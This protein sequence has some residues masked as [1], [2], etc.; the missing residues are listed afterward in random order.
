M[1]YESPHAYKESQDVYMYKKTWIEVTSIYNVEDRK[2]YKIFG[3]SFCT[4]VAKWNLKYMDCQKKIKHNC[5]LFYEI[6]N[7]LVMLISEYRNCLI[8]P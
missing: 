2:L 4:F 8:S 5:L 6:L 3:W 7:D 1:F